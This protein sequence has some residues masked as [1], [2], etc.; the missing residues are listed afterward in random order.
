MPTEDSVSQE[1]PRQFPHRTIMTTLQDEKVPQIRIVSYNI[2]STEYAG[3]DYYVNTPPEHLQT[4][5]RWGLLRTRLEAEL[6]ANS[7]VCL[8]EVTPTWDELLI[9]FF[10]H[11]G[12]TLV[13]GPKADGKMGV[14]IA[15]PRDLQVAETKIVKV[16][17]RLRARASARKYETKIPLVGPWLDAIANRAVVPAVDLYDTTRTRA[18]RLL[19]WPSW[20]N[21]LPQHHDGWEASMKRDNSLVFVRVRPQGTSV[22]LCV[23]TYHM[24]CKFRCPDIMTLHASMVKDLMFEMARTTPFVL[25]GDFNITPRDPVYRM[26]TQ[27]ENC[28]HLLKE[29]LR[30]TVTWRPDYRQVVKS[31]YVTKLGSEPPFTNYAHTA[32]S[33][34]FRDTLDYVF[35]SG[36]EVIDVVALPATPDD[37]ERGVRSFPCTTEPSDHLMVGATFR[38][39]A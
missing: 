9:P 18:G 37:V 1:A 26:L 13:S 19:G 39:G 8:Q 27:G 10:H 2:L 29:S 25:A 16:G 6:K 36:V 3:A 28:D 7:V 11:H 32:R 30:H 35:Y 20:F 23:G 4:S 38:I 24:P 17:D 21:H 5:Y 34:P 14:S 15:V 33:A 31:A 12:Y 22:E